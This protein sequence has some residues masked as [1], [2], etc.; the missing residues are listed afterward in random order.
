MGQRGNVYSGNESRSRFFSSS[1]PCREARHGLAF[2]DT[3]AEAVTRP[4][5]SH[6]RQFH[7]PVANLCFPGAHVHLRW[8]GCLAEADPFGAA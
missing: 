1:P 6:R 8:K 3:H 4:G 5:V 7:P 2:A